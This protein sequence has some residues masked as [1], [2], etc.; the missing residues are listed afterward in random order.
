MLSH[1]DA[2]IRQRR[3]RK[4]IYSTADYW[5]S[6]PRTLQ[7]TSVSMWPNCCLNR[8]YEREED[9]VIRRYFGEL[10]GSVLLDLGCGT[11]RFSRKFAAQGA[12]VTGVD[13]SSGALEI[14]KRQSSGDNPAYRH[15]SVFEMT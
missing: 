13:F 12:R 5:D 4:N 1:L 3:D 15:G 9:D 11:G 14:A 7:G 6:K 2:L 8:L 10:E